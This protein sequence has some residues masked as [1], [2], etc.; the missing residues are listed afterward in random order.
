MN[1]VEVKVEI[2]PAIPGQDIVTAGLAEIGFESFVNEEYCL[3]AYITEDAFDVDKVSALDILKNKDFTSSFTH[4]TIQHENWNAVWESDFQPVEVGNDLLIK[5]PFHTIEK[6][7]KHEVIISPKM[8]FGTGHHETT[9]LM[10]QQMLQTP[11][12]KQSV[13]DM[14]CGTGV[15]AILASKLGAEKVVGIDIEEPAVENAIENAA[16]NSQEKITFIAGDKDVIPNEQYKQIWANIN[17]N[18][19]LD[20]LPLY[21][22]HIEVN[23]T[24]YL[25]GFFTTDCAMLLQAAEK[26][27]FIY[28]NTY[29]RND[30]ACLQFAKD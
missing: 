3:L 19:L 12:Q 16:L 9:Y 23:G 5:A 1:Y 29:S 10:S 11:M 26:E 17:R 25:S 24:L 2:S 28:K 13:L 22:K 30:W 4:K 15:L 21:A 20:Q 8:S 27:G 18:V 7:F 6:Q 14:G